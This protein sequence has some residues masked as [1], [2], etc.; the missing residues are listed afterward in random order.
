MENK[1]P[2][3]CGRNRKLRATVALEER[4]SGMIKEVFGEDRV[5]KYVVGK[6]E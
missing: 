6:L 4:R 1:K 2:V 3:K 5:V